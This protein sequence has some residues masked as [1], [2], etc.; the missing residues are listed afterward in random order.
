MRRE[1]PRD[2]A[3]TLADSAVANGVDQVEH[4]QAASRIHRFGAGL[5]R[6]RRHGDDDPRAS[7]DVGSPMPLASPFRVRMIPMVSTFKNFDPQRTLKLLHRAAGARIGRH[8]NAR[9]AREFGIA[10]AR[11]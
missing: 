9:F 2:S 1:N 4:S 3:N 5:G 11:G 7:F 8:G 10:R 6:S